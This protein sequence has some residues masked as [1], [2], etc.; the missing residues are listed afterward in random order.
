MEPK[1]IASDAVGG[2]AQSTGPSEAVAT[3]SW[4]NFFSHFFSKR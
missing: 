4:L 1:P 2:P 3:S